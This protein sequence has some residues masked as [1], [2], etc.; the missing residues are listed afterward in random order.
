M[1]QDAEISFLIRPRPLNEEFVSKLVREIVVKTN[2]GYYL[3]YVNDTIIPPEDLEQIIKEANVLALKEYKSLWFRNENFDFRLYLRPQER[4]DFIGDG[5]PITHKLGRIHIEVTGS[6][7]EPLRLKTWFMKEKNLGE[8]EA[9]QESIKD[10]KKRIDEFIKIAKIIWNALDPKPIYGIVDTYS[11]T[12]IACLY[13]PHDE[14]I[15][16]L[17][18][19]PNFYWLNFFGPE[20]IEKFGKE[21]LLS[22]PAY[23][24]EELDDGILIIVTPVPPFLMIEYQSKLYEEICRH[25]GWKAYQ[26]GIYDPNRWEP[27]V[28]EYHFNE[29]EFR[30]IKAL[31]K[32]LAKDI[33]KF[34]NKVDGGRV[35]IKL[36]T[37][38][39]KPVPQRAKEIKEWIREELGVEVM[40]DWWW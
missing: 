4:G 13:R 23:R 25:F 11:N 1:G 38:E 31:K 5:T 37:P 34:L 15:L 26:V 40:K 16:N 10:T 2:S 19:E 33:E 7:F 29:K 14:D 39:S 36:D 20:L 22:T 17:K 28:T 24:V 32:Y 21:K 30:D 9:E 18:I 3:D 6:N 8:E 12:S 35:F 27:K